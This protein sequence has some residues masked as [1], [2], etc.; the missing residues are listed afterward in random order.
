MGIEVLISISFERL[1][2][3]G[4]ETSLVEVGVGERGGTL[5]FPQFVT[6]APSDQ[7]TERSM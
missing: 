2:G 4:T 1:A 7:L 5:V 3:L 6:A